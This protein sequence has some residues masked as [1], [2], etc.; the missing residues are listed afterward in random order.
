[1]KSDQT[2]DLTA[3]SNADAACQRIETLGS[4]NRWVKYDQALLT[5]CG[6]TE[7]LWDCFDARTPS[8][9][10]QPVSSGGRAAAWFVKVGILD[11][12][13]RHFR[14]GG[15]VA[16]LVA[17]RYFWTG[18]GQTRAFREFDLL[19]T[20]W[21]A[22]LPVPRPMGA[23]VWKKGL[24]YRAALLTQRIADAQPLAHSEDIDVWRRA[25]AVIASMHRFGVWHADLNVFNVLWDKQGKIW[26]IDFDRGRLCRLTAAQRTENLSR[27][28]RSIKKLGVEQ[29][30]QYWLALVDGYQKA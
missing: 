7:R 11:A 15:L 16:K 22:G 8:L 19:S 14:R 25:G 29:Q 5:E 28:L 13:L 17:S 6:S 30:H 27:L 10:A 23:A 26:L 2:S 9:C 21:C 20:L 3:Q 4:S 12:V 1:L 24:T 18:L